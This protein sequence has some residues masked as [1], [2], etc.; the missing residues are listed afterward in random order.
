MPMTD[1]YEW[2]KS[3]MPQGL[4]NDSPYSNY[5]Y[6][7][8]N[9]INSSVYNNVSQSLLQ[10]DL[11]SLYNSSSMVDTTKMFICL[12]LVRCAQA[13]N[14]DGASVPLTANSFGLTSLKNFNTSLIHQADLIINGK[15]VHQ[16]QPFTGLYTGIKLASQLSLDDLK[17]YGDML[18]IQQMDNPDSMTFQATA[19]A[20]ATTAYSGPSIANNYIEGTPSQQ[21]FNTTADTQGAGVANG[22]IQAKVMVNK[23]I[24][25]N[26]QNL[27]AV[28][29]EAQSLAEFRPIFNVTAGGVAYWYD[30]A[31]IFLKDL[32]DA[33]DKI[34]LTRRLDGILRLYVNTGFTSVTV[35]GT[36][37]VLTADSSMV[38]TSTD[39][40]FTDTCPILINSC[41]G[42]QN[43]WAGANTFA[44][45]NAGLFIARAP[46]YAF[47]TTGAAGAKGGQSNFSTIPA[48][49]MTASRFYYNQVTVQPA[50]QL[51]YLSAM[52]S[53][54]VV[55]KNALYNTFINI[56]GNSNFSQLIQ[57]GVTNIKNIIIVPLLSQSNTGFDF[58]AYRSPIDPVGG[59]SGHPISL[60]NLQV[61]I[62][63]TNQLSTTLDYQFSNFIEQISKYNKESSSEYG[64]DS[65]LWSPSFWANNRFYVVA[66]RSTE[67]DMN[68]PRNVVI[69]FYNNCSYKIDILVFCEYES[70]LRIN[71]GTG[72]I[73]I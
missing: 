17:L 53:K 23:S 56:A 68:T 44:R 61:S 69:S 8:I 27:N 28:I 3:N 35:G 34:G 25:A 16:L 70:T 15:T 4:M 43:T 52:S 50:L 11:S 46:N 60:K 13:F 72:M 41:L 31:I 40:T 18:G 39:T 24:V 48:S 32:L 73:T 9:D 49:P 22:S 38:F 26:R 20:A 58:P 6:N 14:L 2:A 12:P 66:V 37:A 57:S 59:C 7:Y 45:I 1:S 36:G 10:Y 55:Y 67:D 62:G 19:P 65:G 5:Q 64:V 30:Y 21:S 51:E 54:T 63:G 71:I 42:N 47:G 33:M 29:N